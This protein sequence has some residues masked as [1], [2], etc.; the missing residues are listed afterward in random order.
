[1][2]PG[3]HL[4]DENEEGG[5]LPVRRRAVLLPLLAASLT[6]CA[7]PLTK[8]GEFAEKATDKANALLQPT[9]KR[10]YANPVVEGWHPAPSVCR[11]GD[12]FF[13]VSSSFEMM[14]GLPIHHSRDLVNWRLLTHAVT[15]DT[16]LLGP[17]GFS[18]PTL[19]FLNGRFQLSATCASGTVLMSARDILGSW[20]EPELGPVVSPLIQREGFF[21]RLYAQGQGW[22]SALC[23]ERA[24]TP[25]GP[26]EPCPDNPIATQRNNALA[27]LQMIGKGDLV[28]APNGSWWLLVEGARLAGR[29]TPLGFEALLAPVSWNEAGWPVVNE[30]RPIGLEMDVDQLPPTRPWLIPPSREEFNGPGLPPHWTFVRSLAGGLWDLTERPG[31]LRLKG[32]KTGLADATGTPAFVGRRLTGQ[33]LQA[34]TLLDF[35]PLEKNQQ[36]GLALRMDENHHAVLRLSGVPVRRVELA[37]RT[38]GKESII[39]TAPLGPASFGPVRLQVDAQAD[40]YEFSFAGEGMDWTPLGTVGVSALA[41]LDLALDPATRGRGLTVGVYA[42]GFGPMPPADFQSFDWVRS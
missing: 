14:P 3:E 42:S 27:P 7:A 28:Q 19:R 35:A 18:A 4:Q 2:A 34:S 25:Q 31:W 20:T 8:L 12:D 40:R 32:T 33:R 22:D 26:F 11:V 23:V 10:H 13:L 36:A 41:G 17:G 16:E 24:R 30:G 5:A 37:L 1:M 9:K 39:A 38:A 6:G 29:A 21:Y 15:R